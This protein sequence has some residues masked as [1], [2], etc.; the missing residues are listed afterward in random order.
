MD[1]KYLNN[2]YALNVYMD[3]YDRDTDEFDMAGHWGMDISLS[4]FDKDFRR[5]KSL[6]KLENCFRAELNNLFWLK[7]SELKEQE[8][9][10]APFTFDNY[11]RTWVIGWVIAIRKNRE[12]VNQLWVKSS[13]KTFGDNYGDLKE[14]DYSWGMISVNQIPIETLLQVL[15]YIKYAKDERSC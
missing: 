6:V 11:E 7:N 3:A 12:G 15:E 10:V 13:I 14:E 1:L 8:I 2:E 4:D 5:V 9:E